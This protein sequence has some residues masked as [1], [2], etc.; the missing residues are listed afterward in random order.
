LSSPGFP[1][2][3]YTLLCPIS[4]ALSIPKL[5]IHSYFISDSIKRP[6][7]RRRFCSPS[8]LPVSAPPAHTTQQHRFSPHAELSW[9]VLL[10]RPV[11]VSILLRHFLFLTANFRFLRVFSPKSQH[12]PHSLSLLNTED[13][14]FPSPRFSHSRLRASEPGERTLP[15]FGLWLSSSKHRLF[16][17]P[18]SS[19]NS[20]PF[21]G[22]THRLCVFR[23]FFPNR[24]VY[25]HDPPI[26]CRLR[27]AGFSVPP[28]FSPVIISPTFSFIS[29]FLS[30]NIPVSSSQK[31]M[32]P[33][34][35]HSPLPAIFTV[36]FSSRPTFSHNQCQ[37]AVLT[38]MNSNV[39]QFN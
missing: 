35:A 4:G 7:S 39:S 9:R 34:I 28:P 10:R 17:L 33:R 26:V 29:L 14:H 20:Q 16:F 3:N 21:S 13:D 19:V 2:A 38:G 6:M 22:L 15:T 5:G 25:L 37:S 11:S 36:L 24:S 18:G 1:L 12:Q 31:L 23:K 8:R 27:K 30:K 32:L